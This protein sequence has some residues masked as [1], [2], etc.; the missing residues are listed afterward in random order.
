MFWTSLKIWSTGRYLMKRNDFLKMCWVLIN[1][2]TFI[3]NIALYTCSPGSWYSFSSVSFIWHLTFFSVHFVLF[4]METNISC[5]PTLFKLLYFPLLLS[6]SG[7][8]MFMYPIW[9]FSSFPTHL[10]CFCDY[11]GTRAFP[12]VMTLTFLTYCRVCGVVSFVVS[13]GKLMAYISTYA[14]KEI[15]FHFLYFSLVSLLF[16]DSVLILFVTS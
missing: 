13:G 14:L 10:V 7:F 3:N 12:W 11:F 2:K 16:L 4:R 15:I 1:S 6:E 8:A 9:I 5:N